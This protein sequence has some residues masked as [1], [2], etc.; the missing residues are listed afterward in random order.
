MWPRWHNWPLEAFCA[1]WYERWDN[2]LVTS[3]K[4]DSET[5]RARGHRDKFSIT[6]GHTASHFGLLNDAHVISCDFSAA[7]AAK[8][9]HFIAAQRCAQLWIRLNILLRLHSSTEI[10][11]ILKWHYS[12]RPICLL[13]LGRWGNW[14]LFSFH[15]MRQRWQNRV[16]VQTFGCWCA[17]AWPWPNLFHWDPLAL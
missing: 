9:A 14:S 8:I 13:G 6:S 11:Q 17:D 7:I 2:K 15:H 1:Q 5:R 16:D 10:Q 3:K 4:K 12:V